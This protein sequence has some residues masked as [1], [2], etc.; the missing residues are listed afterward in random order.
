[1]EVA[2]PSPSNSRSPRSP[3]NRLQRLMYLTSLTKANHTQKIF[4]PGS[5][6]SAWWPMICLIC[7]S[8]RIWNQVAMTFDSPTNFPQLRK[9][10]SWLVKLLSI[11][12]SAAPSPIRGSLTNSAWCLGIQSRRLIQINHKKRVKMHWIITNRFA[13]A[14]ASINCIKANKSCK[15]N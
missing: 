1:M 7:K 12:R 10:M 11:A 8:W 6:L 15:K 13:L 3:E 9:T 2:L 4:P 14:D 5:D